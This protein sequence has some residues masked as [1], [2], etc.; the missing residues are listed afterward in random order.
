LCTT[1]ASTD[2][3]GI[4][5]GSFDLLAEASLVPVDACTSTD[6]HNDLTADASAAGRRST[7][8]TKTRGTDLV[9][10]TGALPTREIPRRVRP[11]LLRTPHLEGR[12]SVQPL[13]A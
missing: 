8:A 7:A 2:D 9:V 11:G 3:F 6:P 4:L 1:L 10:R 5:P 13:V 12:S